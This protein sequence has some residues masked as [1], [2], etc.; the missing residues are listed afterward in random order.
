[1][2]KL[3]NG[4][5]VITDS[6]AENK[7]RQWELHN[8][9][10]S[11]SVTVLHSL[12]QETVAAQWLELK[13]Q[14][15]VC[16]QVPEALC[17]GTVPAQHTLTYRA[18]IYMKQLKCSCRTQT[19]DT[20]KHSSQVPKHVMT[21]FAAPYHWNPP[22]TNSIHLIFIF[23]FIVFVCKHSIIGY[24]RISF[25]LWSDPLYLWPIKLTRSKIR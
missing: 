16:W 23:I 12:W 10:G 4:H 15:L 8:L 2:K 5:F 11:P 19:I 17:G 7:H 20:H 6:Y 18:V 22:I 9:A 21:S 14:Q 25:L 3:N 1:M 24:N 13:S